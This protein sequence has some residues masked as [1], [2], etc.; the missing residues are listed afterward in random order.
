MTKLIFTISIVAAVAS[1]SRADSTQSTGFE[2]FAPGPFVSGSPLTQ[3][4]WG[5][6][7]NYNMIPTVVG[8]PVGSGLQALSILTH[9]DDTTQASLSG[10][11]GGTPSVAVSAIGEVGMTS[12]SG[13]P[14]IGNQLSC[15][16]LLRTPAAGTQPNSAYTSLDYGWRLEIQPARREGNVANLNGRINV[17]DGA[18][19]QVGVPNGAYDIQF[20]GTNS[21][22]AVT[23]RSAADKIYLQI[24]WPFIIGPEI[25][26]TDAA[27]KVA[28]INGLDYA[29][30]Y[31]VEYDVQYVNGTGSAMFLGQSRSCANDVITVRVFDMSGTL[32]GSMTGS[33]WE[34]GYRTGTWGSPTF[35]MDCMGVKAAKPAGAGQE[36]GV[37]DQF[38]MT[39]AEG[40]SELSLLASDTIIQPSEQ[41]VVDVQLDGQVD[42]AVG[43]QIF[44]DFDTARLQVDSISV[45][46]GSSFSREIYSNVNNATGK[47]IYASGIPDSGSGSMDELS[48]ARVVFN[49]VPGTED[50]D[51]SGLVSFTQGL[52][53]G[54]RVA[55]SGG[56]NLVPALTA[57]GDIKIDATAPVFAGLPTN[58]SIASDAGTVVGAYVAAPTVTAS[59]ICDGAT[60]VALLVTY[61][62]SSTATT[63]PAN[64][65]FP[66][67]T[68]TL[69]YSTVDAAGNA[70]SA[71]RTIIVADH[72]LLDA[73][74][75][76]NGVVVG[77]STRATRMKVGASTQVVS[78]AMTGA[79]GTISGL[80]VPV[81]ASYPCV[82]AKGTTHTVTDTAATSLVGTRYSADFSLRQGD[83]NDDD[84]IDILDFA[85]YIGDF[86][87]AGP[88]DVSNFN[89][90]F[91]V[92]TV[93][94]TFISIGFLQTGEV[95]GGSFNAG[96][97][98]KGITV[99][100]LRRMGLGHLA[101]ADLDANGVVNQADMMRH[102]A[103]QGMAEPTV[104]DEPV[105]RR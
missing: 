27:W 14:V 26:S 32:V 78:V 18:V 65:M 82:S 58:V 53:V 81:A 47:I 92:G 87:L 13:A 79:N 1:A 84:L 5:W 11:V 94:F 62:N 48:V 8:A 56:V 103:G 44:L 6:L 67:G 66:Q 61:P 60:A 16:F 4:G 86:G 76:L 12:Y 36:L 73:T 69:A 20:D 101:V 52:T 75:L 29:T 83:S 105:R 98:R 99:R 43:A 95:C 40:F 22:A 63:W 49:V 24:D 89:A 15:S 46:P 104:A 28:F 55:A 80:P 39:A 10:A 54:S 17:G 9:P 71:S 21:G 7:A 37:I 64:G 72:Q 45:A 74:L 97:P 85:I 19:Q 50:C 100:E 88:S 34:A 70:A 68:S 42:P 77:N 91:V 38:S 93:D 51:A 59:D 102:L 2:E 23:P 90:D 96:V 30:W 3:G 31:R 33:T 57:L 35:A 41:L 25:D